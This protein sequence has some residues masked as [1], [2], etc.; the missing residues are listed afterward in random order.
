MTG[1]RVRAPQLHGR[2]G[3]L[4]TGGRSLALADL[5]GKIVLLD[6][7]TFCCANCLHVIDELR[8]LEKAYADTLVVIGVHSPK[9]AHETDH[10][11]VA[12]AVERYEVDHAVLDDPDLELWR[13]YAVRAWPTLV[14]VD[15]EGYVVAQAA[16]EGQTSSLARMIDDL[17]AVHEAK[18]TLHR[19][20]GPFVAPPPV[21]TSL[22]FPASAILLPAH[23]TGRDQDSLLVADAGHHQL[24]ELALDGEQ[25]LRRI[26]SGERGRADGPAETAS[27]AESG[28]LALLPPGVAPFDVI[29]ADTAN[30][31]LRGVRL[32]DGAVVATVDL[33][34]GLAEARTI[35]GQIP[36]VLSPWDVAWWPAIER[37]VVAAAGVHL[38]LAYDPAR[39]TVEV[40]AGT[41][42]EG[43]RDGPALDGWLAQ[44]SGLAVDGDRI[45]FVD[46]ETS[47]LR[48]LD[49]E[50]RLHTHIGEGLFDFGHVDGPAAQ[51]RLQHPLGVVVLGDGTVAILDTY[52]GA[53]RRYVEADGQVSTIADGLAEP[54]GGVLVDGDLVVVESAAH[55][56]VRA[57]RTSALVAGP[58]LRTH[59]PPMPMRPGPVRVSVRFVPPPGR[60]L[61]ERYGPSTRL[62]ISASPSGLVLHGAGDSTELTRE[63]TL[64]SA[65][66]G[67]LH[68]TAQAAACDDDPAIEH[69]ACYV[70]RQDWGVPVIIDPGGAAELE[71]VL[72][73]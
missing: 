11:A 7:W 56:L 39:A 12:A 4:N 10:A 62:S 6:F 36:A 60:K 38:L 34:A 31:L 64:A 61:D 1:A 28:G 14:L 54:S 20:S 49:I 33:A 37:V 55:R 47:A 52:N 42:V 59:R 19:G 23:R 26:G 44:P 24:V 67:V 2:G 35:T 5:R 16:G 66:D 71:L 57:V 46:S 43:L 9:F 21:S 51:A 13:Q 53:V 69:P 41:T 40:L 73:G 72:L 30:H 17:I 29:V 65:P 18:G 32:A 3:W 8:P 22:R 63:L 45:W 48:T 27:F 68:V 50:G 70:S 15:P 58:A 25:V